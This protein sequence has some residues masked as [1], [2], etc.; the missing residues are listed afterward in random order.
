[1]KSMEDFVKRYSDII[2]EMADDQGIIETLL[3]AYEQYLYCH[4]T[5]CDELMDYIG[6]QLHK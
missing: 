5:R 2:C 3:E 4:T 1:M 6:D